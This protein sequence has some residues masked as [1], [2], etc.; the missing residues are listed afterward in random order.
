MFIS[1]LKQTISVTNSF[2]MKINLTMPIGNLFRHELKPT[3]TCFNHVLGVF[4]FQARRDLA[5]S[6]NNL[7]FR[8]TGAL[9]LTMGRR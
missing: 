2:T 5:D 3:S 7:P 9:N 8:T 1:L 6:A 4:F